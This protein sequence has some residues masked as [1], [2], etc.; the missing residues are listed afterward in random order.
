MAT[1]ICRNIDFTLEER[2]LPQ[3]DGLY[4]EYAKAFV[5][6]HICGNI[7]FIPERI[8]CKRLHEWL[9]QEFNKS[10]FVCLS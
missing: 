1:G 8:D 6:S 7:R 5:L 4:T 9:V 10:V 3:T 2:R